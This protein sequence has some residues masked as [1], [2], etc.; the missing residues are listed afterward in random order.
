MVR[1]LTL[2]LLAVIVGA[3]TEVT[4]TLRA[5]SIICVPLIDR[6]LAL[7]VLVVRELDAVMVLAAMLVA[8]ML[9]ELSIAVVPLTTSEPT[10]AT[11]EVFKVATL[12][13]LR[14][15]SKTWVPFTLRLVT[16]A[17]LTLLRL[18][19]E[20]NTVV[21]PTFREPTVVAPVVLIE[22]TFDILRDESNT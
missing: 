5:L 11:P 13:R 10:V 9:R 14:P 4:V 22:A 17:A 19:D 2:K 16:L 20:S 21:A 15:E 3:V 1:L 7:K 8:F 18:R 12:D 6:L